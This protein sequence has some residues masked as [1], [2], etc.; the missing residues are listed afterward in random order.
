MEDFKAIVVFSEGDIVTIK[1]YAHNIQE[2]V[3]NL[4]QIK[5]IINIIQVERLS[6]RE[7]WNFKNG[8]IDFLSLRAA[9]EEI[10]NEAQLKRALI[11]PASSIKEV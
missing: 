9:R 6:D 2:L 4:I 5:E 3:D 11:G 8:E 10:S 1:N 7:I